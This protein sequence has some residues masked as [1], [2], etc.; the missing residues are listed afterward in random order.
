LVRRYT[1][2][3][4]TSPDSPPTLGQYITQQRR[5]DP[6]STD[7]P[8][9]DS[10]NSFRGVKR[11]STAKGIAV[12]RGHESW[13]NSVAFSRDGSR[14]VTA[15]NDT[16]A[17][18]WDAATG[19]QIAVLR[20]HD[21][22]VSSAISPD[23]SRLVTAS[24]DYTARIW[25]SHLQTTSTKDLI[26][27]ACARLAGLTK[28]TAR[29]CASPAIPTSCLRSTCANELK[30]AQHKKDLRRHGAPAGRKNGCDVS[31]LR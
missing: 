18:I 24:W 5:G 8:V 10:R 6:G 31:F 23:G 30:M 7:A 21:G 2:Q 13:L 9:G 26:P 12:L 16:T 11:T 15:S 20:G 4:Y 29:K 22:I 1:N 19:Q 17:R 14:I 28:L 25:D 3:R 27:K